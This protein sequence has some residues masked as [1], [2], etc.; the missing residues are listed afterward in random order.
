MLV[1]TEAATSGVQGSDLQ[2]EIFLANADTA[3][4]TWDPLTL[5]QVAAGTDPPPDFAV[6]PPPFGTLYS[7]DA[8][9]RIQ[10]TPEGIVTPEGVLLFAGAPK[11]VPPPR[12][13]QTTTA[14]A[15]DAAV[16]AAPVVTP[17]P[18]ASEPAGLGSTAAVATV[19]GAAS[20][21]LNM[22]PEPFPS[23]PTL[24]DKRPKPRPETLGDTAAATAKQG[25]AASDALSSRLASLRPRARPG[26]MTTAATQT[27]TPQEELANTAAAASLALNTVQPSA[28]AVSVSKKP[29]ARPSGLDQ[30]VDAAVAAAVR[31][32]AP[33]QPA[34]LPRQTASAAPAASAAKT[35][36]VAPAAS[37]APEA[38]SEPEV[39]TAARSL[40]TN[41]SVARQATTKDALNLS[42][43]A[44]LGVFGTAS[45]RYAMVR[46]PGGSVRKV[47][48]GD[49]LD[50][51]QVAAITANAVQYQKGGRIVT[52]SLP[53]G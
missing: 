30:A 21:A 36:S 49:R 18:A 31:K 42:R 26:A 47:V 34:A 28:L 17:T 33:Q 43:V 46:Q 8:D 2:D 4:Q 27:A 32:S 52:L 23:D 9:G 48:V 35:A 40:P 44:L 1:T 22:T 12:P 14:A 6:P 41:A 13:A 29:A 50:G 10:P 3:P 51:G 20:A 5:P 11:V 38:Q 16:P 15:P 37:A 19:P 53:T 45:G 7:F 25:E 24:A 39:Q